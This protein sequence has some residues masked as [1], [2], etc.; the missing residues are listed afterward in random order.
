MPKEKQKRNLITPK[1]ET[2]DCYRR[3]G[4]CRKADFKKGSRCNIISINM[5]KSKNIIKHLSI[6]VIALLLIFSCSKNKELEKTNFHTNES[7]VDV[8]QVND[9]AGSLLF[10]INDMKNNK[11]TTK[12][13]S[14][15]KEIKNCN[16][17]VTFYIVSYKDGGF[18]ILSADNR[19]QPVLGY[20]TSNEFVDDESLYPDGLKF[21]L[22]DA[23]SQITDIQNSN[24][25]QS[26]E[27]NLAWEHIQQAIPTNF[28]DKKII[29]DPYECYDHIE[30]Y[31]VSPLLNTIWYQTGG[32]NDELPF[33]RCNGSY[34][35][36]YAGCVIIA[37]A[38]V[39]KYYQYPTNYDWASMPSN[40][41]TT[42][43]AS[44]IKDIHNAINNVYSNEPSYTCSGTGVSSSAD[45]GKVLKTQFNYH[46]ANMEDYDYITVRNNLNSNKPVILAGSGSTGGHMWVCDGYTYSEYF[47]DDCTGFTTYTYFHMNWGWH[48]SFDGYF[49]F[50]N[51]NPRNTNFNSNKKMIYDITP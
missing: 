9:I 30:S 38:Q 39:M 4:T 36:A 47:F 42:T 2:L 41:A 48:G 21:W 18:V 43:T 40:Y 5:V 19:V 23:I 32:F 6:L 16:N 10:P 15:I 14:N 44:F 28:N 20:S 12:T 51:F 8:S 35:H 3:S 24:I 31:S 37:M 26:N 1:V 50:N 7:F 29:E 11:T 22:E 46:V 49:A 17:K 13:V 34:Y 33:I 27:I 45:M 25:K